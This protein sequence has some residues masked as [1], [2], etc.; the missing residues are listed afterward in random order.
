MA[1]FWVSY[2]LSQKSKL[3]LMEGKTTLVIKDKTII[4]FI[5]ISLNQV[6]C[7]SVYQTQYNMFCNVLSEVSPCLVTSSI[8]FSSEEMRL[9]KALY[10]SLIYTRRNTMLQLQNLLGSFRTRN[11]SSRSYHSY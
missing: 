2:F 7:M 11:K 10:S 4:F 3:D 9:S 1:C 6:Q 8:E 5:D